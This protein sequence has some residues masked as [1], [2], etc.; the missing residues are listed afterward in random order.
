MVFTK[1]SSAAANTKRKQRYTRERGTVRASLRERKK[2]RLR[3]EVEKNAVR[4]KV[5]RLLGQWRANPLSGG[6][7]NALSYAGVKTVVGKLAKQVPFRRGSSVFVDL[8]SGCGIP[9][10]F[11]ALR[12]GVC[13]IG[14]EKDPNLVELAREYAADAGVEDLCRFECL[15][16]AQLRTQWFSDHGA[17]HVM[18]FDV[19]FGAGVLHALYRRLGAVRSALVGCNPTRTQRYWPSSFVQLGQVSD[20]AKLC[21]R[22]ASS[23]KFAVWSNGQ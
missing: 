3:G 11:T 23:F 15:D 6:T 22:G 2:R 17:T 4:S 9:C 5:N 14:L 12:Y 10:I 18:A 1:T 7:N 16:V 8:G 13:C 20:S 19:C 21:G